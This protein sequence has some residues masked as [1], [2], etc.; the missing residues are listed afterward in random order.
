MGLK[1]ERRTNQ[2][3]S[4]LARTGIIGIFPSKTMEY[5]IEG[6]WVPGYDFSYKNPGT[7]ISATGEAYEGTYEYINSS[8][9]EKGFYL[10]LGPKWMLKEQEKFSGLLCSSISIFHLVSTY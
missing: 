1:Y 8:T 2:K 5:L 4:W 9:R 10:R 6:E 3:M 7:Y